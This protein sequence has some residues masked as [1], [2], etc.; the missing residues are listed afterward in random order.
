MV[1][2]DHKIQGSEPSRED[3]LAW[4]VDNIDELRDACSEAG[5]SNAFIRMISSS[6]PRKRH[7]ILMTLYRHH[8]DDPPDPKTCEKCYNF[9]GSFFKAIWDGD[10]EHAYNRADENN[11]ELMEKVFDDYELGR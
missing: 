2:E 8:H 5:A 6:V 7:N 11:T 9:G 3:Y 1:D 4:A 10:L